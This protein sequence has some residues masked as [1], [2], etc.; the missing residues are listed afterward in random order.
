MVITVGC[1]GD[2][3]TFWDV[4]IAI[5]FDGTCDALLHVVD[6]VLRVVGWGSTSLWSPVGPVKILTSHGCLYYRNGGG[7][8]KNAVLPERGRKESTTTTMLHHMR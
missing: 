8:Q 4:C 3:A 5:L 7:E 1:V 2:V 6:I